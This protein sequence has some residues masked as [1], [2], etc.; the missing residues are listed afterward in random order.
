MKNILSKID[1][2]VDHHTASTFNSINSMNIAFPFFLPQPNHFVNWT[3]NGTKDR[4]ESTFYIYTGVDN[5]HVHFNMC[6][7]LD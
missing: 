1:Y 3:F 7:I 5:L 4:N 6:V 2:C